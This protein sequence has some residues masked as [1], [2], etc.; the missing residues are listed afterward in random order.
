MGS[1]AIGADGAELVGDAEDDAGGVGSVGGERRV[2][3]HEGEFAV[4]SAAGEASGDD[5]LALDVAVDAEVA[6]AVALLGLQVTAVED[7]G[8]IGE[9]FELSAV[10]IELGDELPWIALVA[11]RRACRT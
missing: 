4:D 2:V 5:L 6:P 3:G 9:M 1:L 7:E 10:G 11:C 8:R